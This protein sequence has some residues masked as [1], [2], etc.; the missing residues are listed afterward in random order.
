ME[1]N[2]IYYRDLNPNIL[3]RFKPTE[4]PGHETSSAIIIELSAILRCSF[5]AITFSE[6]AG[7]IYAY[8]IDIATGYDSPG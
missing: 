5:N 1:Q 6:F 8:I 7:K 4:F 2:Q 3:Q